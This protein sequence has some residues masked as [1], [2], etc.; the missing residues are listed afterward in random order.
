MAFSTGQILVLSGVYIYHVHPT[1]TALPTYHL[2]LEFKSENPTN[3]ALLPLSNT[4]PHIAYQRPTS[5]TSQA[6]V[7]HKSNT[8][9]TQVKHKSNLSHP[10]LSP[11]LAPPMMLAR[12]SS[13]RPPLLQQTQSRLF[14]NITSSGGQATV[15]Q[16]GFYGSGGSR[17]SSSPDSR[18]RPEAVAH[19]ADIKSLHNV[20]SE[21]DILESKVRMKRGI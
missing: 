3:S 21:L 10:A 5:N 12:L 11:L 4:S 15:G 17:S 6:Q 1:G 14:N 2:I 18:Q 19:A 7:K 9:Q 13:L 16:G 20:I 8:S